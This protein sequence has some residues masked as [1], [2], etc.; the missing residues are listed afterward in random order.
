MARV[1][2][3]F[4]LFVIFLVLKVLILGGK[5]VLEVG[6]EA[7][8]S[9]NNTNISKHISGL[10]PIVGLYGIMLIISYDRFSDSFE[11]YEE[12][13]FLNEFIR[14]WREF[15]IEHVNKFDDE[16][17]YV[18]DK[19]KEIHDEYS[20]MCDEQREGNFF[21]VEDEDDNCE[22]YCEECFY[23]Y[24]KNTHFFRNLI[25][26]INFLKEDSNYA[27]EILIQFLALAEVNK[28]NY[29]LVEYI[30]NIEL[31]ISKSQLV[32]QLKKYKYDFDE[33]DIPNKEICYEFDEEDIE[34]DEYFEQE[35]DYYEK[36]NKNSKDPYEIFL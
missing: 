33:Y 1:L 28:C 15:Y 34:D 13:T 7:Y 6:T 30:L 24:T 32:N 9:V 22:E 2:I 3:Y 5:K 26:N 20:E 19:L 18:N 36:V 23:E 27:L 31:S 10:S 4:L 17:Y 11:K 29:N 8:D 12:K 21:N 25:K 16:L 35:D 14:F